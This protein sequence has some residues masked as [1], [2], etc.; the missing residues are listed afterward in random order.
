M[1]LVFSMAITTLSSQTATSLEVIESAQTPDPIITIDS[2]Q[3]L[4]SVHSITIVDGGTGYTD[5][6]LVSSDCPGFAVDFT[7]TGGVI[8]SIEP[9]VNR[10]VCNADPASIEVDNQ[11]AGL[12]ADFDSEI[13]RYLHA[14]VTNGGGETLSTNEVWFFFDG[15]SP[16]SM[17]STDF[18]PVVIKSNWFSGETISVISADE[19]P[20]TL[21][22]RMSLT[23]GETSVSRTIIVPA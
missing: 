21:H 11:P 17:T 23:V 12:N 1:L 15:S 10:G 19:G 16:T 2:A 4:N 13:K 22:T 7:V 9:I 20:T 3:Y 5:G 6:Q 8:T 18:S 14:D